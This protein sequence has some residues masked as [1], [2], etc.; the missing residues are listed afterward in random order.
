LSSDLMISPLS[1]RRPDSRETIVQNYGDSAGLHPW[2][3]TR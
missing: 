2:N 1:A 3:E